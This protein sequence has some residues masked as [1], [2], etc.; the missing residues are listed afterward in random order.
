MEGD[1]EKGKEREK[2]VDQSQAL[3]S[4]VSEKEEGK[5]IAKSQTA[6]AGLPELVDPEPFCNHP[7]KIIHGMDRCFYVLGVKCCEEVVKNDH[8]S[9]CLVC[10]K[11]WKRE[12][13]VGDEPGG[14]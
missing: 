3:H 10:R 13:S 6:D 7:V 9:R 2:T 5:T 14:G 11:E 4:R 1:F 12:E 8:G